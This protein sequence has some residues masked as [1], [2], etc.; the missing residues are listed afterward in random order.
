MDDADR[1]LY[2]P[3]EETGIA[4]YCLGFMF[5]EN[6]QLVVLIAKDHPKQMVGL[7][8]GIG[9]KIEVGESPRNA[10]VREFREEAGVA[11][12]PEDWEYRA[13]LSTGKISK[14]PFEIYCFRAIDQDAFKYSRTM[15]REMIVK[16]TSFDIKKRKDTLRN[17]P[18]LIALALDESGIKFPVILKE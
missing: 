6:R 3:F 15:E 18:V 8:N 17:L 7:L 13:H 2:H 10:M 5:S 1:L 14:T 12:K 11:T 4:R 16:V 9:G